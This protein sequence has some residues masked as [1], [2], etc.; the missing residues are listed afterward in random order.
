MCT[1]KTMKNIENTMILLWIAIWITCITI[2]PHEII[3][4][5]LAIIAGIKFSE[6]MMKLT[7]MVIYKY[8]KY[9]N[10]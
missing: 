5:I 6:W 9:K 4:F 2:I 1:I 7:Q 8:D 3:H 10:V